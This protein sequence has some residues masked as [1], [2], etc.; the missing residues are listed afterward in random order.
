MKK[1]LRH[2]ACGNHG[3]LSVDVLKRLR[4]CLPKEGSHSGSWQSIKEVLVLRMVEL[5][6]L[7]VNVYQKERLSR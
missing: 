3:S 6:C 7:Q 5:S 1:I 2:M 4:A